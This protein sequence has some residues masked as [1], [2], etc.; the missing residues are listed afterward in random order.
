MDFQAGAPKARFAS[1]L[2]SG[3]PG[4]GFRVLKDHVP[5]LTSKPFYLPTLPMTSQVLGAD[6]GLEYT[7]LLVSS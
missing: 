6:P 5:P 3:I 4:W 7:P 1:S 2:K